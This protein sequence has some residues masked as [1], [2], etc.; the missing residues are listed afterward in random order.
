V[1]W[2]KK[3]TLGCALAM[4]A[5]GALAGPAH[6]PGGPWRSILPT[7]TKQP[8]VRVSPFQLDRTPVTNAQFLAFVK[9]QSQWQRTRVPEV[10][11]DSQYLRHWKSP[12]EL[13]PQAQ[14]AQPVTSV[15]WFAARA[16]CESRGQRLP[17]W[18][19]WE[20]AAAADEH[21]KDAR[22]SAGWQQQVLNWYSRPSNGPLA[23][24]G[25]SRPNV[26]GVQDLHGLIWEWVED[27]NALMVSGDSREQGDPDTLKFC[28]SGA[29]AFENRDEY[30]V[31]MRIALL[32]S[33]QAS[34]TTLNLGF[35]CAASSRV[36]SVTPSTALPTDSMYQVD[37][38]LETSTGART[39]FSAR[40]GRPRIVTMFYS[41]CSATCPLTINTL[42][43]VDAALTPVERAGLGMLLVS[44]DPEHDT[45]QALQTLAKERRVT[46]SRWVLARAS[47][48]DTRKL[49]AMLGIQ[50]R[51]LSTGDFEHSSVLVL[52][53]AEGR[54]R[55]RS[56][57]LGEPDPA[58]IEAAR[59]SIIAHRTANREAP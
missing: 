30:A 32:S 49:A 35:R 23:S 10:L 33:L 15:S 12:V 55:A 45:P 56:A 11:A 31:A 57:K 4:F 42:R 48:S 7:G 24:V 40:R 26:Y 59:S 20:L 39:R 44:L 25:Q 36:A 1:V 54:V 37:T 34:S 46:D 53:D 13:G 3:A 14:P 6:V 58:F 47:A 9:S 27:F 21:Q 16:Y 5:H 22:A 28:G 19:E 29:L 17:T 38:S 8:D 51:E 2:W 18:Y 52:L 50:Y 41:R 43:A